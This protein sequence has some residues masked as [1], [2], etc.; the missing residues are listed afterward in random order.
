MKLK[1]S[2]IGIIDATLSG[3]SGDK[4]L[5][6]LIDL[7][8]KIEN[9]KHVAKI[10]ADVLPG[11][12]RIDIETSS[13]ERGDVAAKLVTVKSKEDVSERKGSI[14]RASIQKAAAKLDLSNWGKSLSLSIVDTLL[15]AESHVHG[16]SIKEVTLHE[17]GS[18]DTLV[19]ILGTVDLLE[20]LGLSETDWWSSSIAVGEGTT[21]F[22]GRDY[23]VPPPA[24]AEILRRHKYPMIL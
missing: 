3:V 24:V 1:K 13:V 16:H 17:L 6:A 12:R 8:A 21:R 11:T 22:S 23:P 18:A 5:G 19:D 2:N 15:A 9:L 20:Q 7:G 14:I 4:Y 10:V